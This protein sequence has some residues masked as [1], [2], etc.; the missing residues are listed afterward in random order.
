MNLLSCGFV[1][2]SDSRQFFLIQ[3]NYYDPR[4]TP[5]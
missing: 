2:Y 1:N 4:L 3:Q 5:G